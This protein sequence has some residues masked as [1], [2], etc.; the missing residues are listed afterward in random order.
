MIKK[1][2]GQVAEKPDVQ[3]LIALAA[4][5]TSSPE[6]IDSA[7]LTASDNPPFYPAD[8]DL[9]GFFLKAKSDPALDAKLLAAAALSA[10]MR[11]VA[12]AV[13]RVSDRQGAFTNF[14]WINEESPFQS[15]VYKVLRTPQIGLENGA[16]GGLKE[17]DDIDVSATVNR[18]V[19]E[20]VIDAVK[21][22]IK[23]ESSDSDLL[24]QAFDK[25]MKDA[26]DKKKQPA[27]GVEAF[28][29][30]LGNTPGLQSRLR[31]FVDLAN[32]LISGLVATEKQKLFRCRD[33]AHAIERGWGFKVDAFAHVAGISK[34]T[35][36]KF[37]RF[38][39]TVEGLKKEARAMGLSTI[40]GEMQGIA[41]YTLADAPSQITKNFYGHEGLAEIIGF[42]R[43][44]KQKDPATDTRAIWAAFSSDAIDALAEKMRLSRGH[45]REI[46]RRLAEA[47]PVKGYLNVEAN[48]Y[49]EALAGKYKSRGGDLSR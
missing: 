37:D 11:E 5:P 40:A 30:T 15:K 20:E 2:F 42:A 23:I 34:E 9:T 45:L 17:G 24:E 12:L 29:A 41:I 46:Y 1:E 49:R 32:D 43:L 18:E 27:E 44:M 47:A 8:K 33:D 14:I 22:V 4:S 7:M 48:A 25:A 13:H 39:E 35:A 6:D 21:L 3:A 31:G 10:P 26:F 36:E 19:Y 16:W 38:C 28:M